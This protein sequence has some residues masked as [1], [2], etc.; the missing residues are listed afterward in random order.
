MASGDLDVH[1][2]VDADTLEKVEAYCEKHWIEKFSFSKSM[3]LPC[4][5]PGDLRTS[6]ANQGMTCVENVLLRTGGVI[7][8]TNIWGGGFYSLRIV[9]YLCR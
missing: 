5:K 4:V 1:E 6:A 7:P 9:Y 2:F 8:D 3:N